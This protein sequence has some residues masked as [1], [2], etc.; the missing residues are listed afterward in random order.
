MGLESA[1]IGDT[2]AVVDP[3][4]GREIYG[5]V[6][7]VTADA[8]GRYIYVKGH[9]IKVGVPSAGGYAPVP[10]PAPAEIYT[11][12]EPP[13]PTGTAVITRVTPPEP[14]YVGVP[15]D[16]RLITLTPMEEGKPKGEAGVYLKTPEKVTYIG[17]M[18]PV[19]K[20]EK[21]I[22]AEISPTGLTVTREK[23]VAGPA[24]PI[25]ET[26][27][28][29]YARVLRSIAGETEET[30]KRL[31]KREE[32]LGKQLGLSQAML[33]STGKEISVGEF[34]QQIAGIQ[35]AKK[36]VKGES[37]ESLLTKHVSEF[38]PHVEEESK[39]GII[40]RTGLMGVG[41]LETISFG[42]ITPVRAGQE[43]GGIVWGQPTGY[44]ERAETYKMLGGIFTV[45]GIAAPGII[46]P[47]FPKTPTITRTATIE[48][49]VGKEG[50]KISKGV[51][52]QEFQVLEP[53]TTTQTVKRFFGFGGKG[54][55]ETYQ[56]LVT[57]MH[58]ADKKLSTG[59][60]KVVL[61]GKGKPTESIFSYGAKSQLLKMERGLGTFYGESK[62]WG[63]RPTEKGIDLFT[64]GKIKSL[65]RERG[66][67]E[68]PEAK[69]ILYGRKARGIS[70]TTE[71]FG[72]GGE[73]AIGKMTLL[74]EQ[75]IFPAYKGRG[76]KTPFVDYRY[77]VHPLIRDLSIGLKKPITKVTRRMRT[78][79][80]DVGYGIARG[81]IRGRYAKKPARPIGFGLLAPRAVSQFPRAGARFPMPK[82][83]AWARL[84]LGY[85]KAP[86]IYKDVFE[87]PKKIPRGVQ[88][89]ADVMFPKAR[90][91]VGL[92]LGTLVPTRQAKK[93]KVGLKAFDKA[94]AG[95]GLKA[96][97]KG[98]TGFG[99]LYKTTAKITA[100][101]RRRERAKTR[102]RFLTSQDFGF[103][104]G[105]G[106]GGL[107][108]LT[109]TTPPP[110]FIIPWFPKGKVRKR[111]AELFGLP[112]VTTK[113]Q[114]SLI[115]LGLDIFGKK[116]KRL[117]GLE[118]RPLLR[119]KRGRKRGWGFI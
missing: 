77:T 29:E 68:A 36:F 107:K 105:P 30:V 118:I 55:K 87:M 8:G 84:G 53:P 38:I 74:R 46:S 109:P 89:Q 7:G 49:I 28:P 92:G 16:S 20:G 31:E 10:Q 50:Q 104:F 43:F 26:K 23:I 111:K 110:P 99:K 93:G 69:T 41:A 85:G 71:G 15:T 60:G 9:K 76:G 17:E 86:K 56:A 80:L 61:F 115:A 21:L 35:R 2:V 106:L 3:K 114:P 88:R 95:F 14:E 34:S 6:T 96:A 22:G 64:A 51:G 5:K 67:L 102:F 91:R 18:E 62:F 44:S 12:A 73:K 94:I 113:Y 47:Y 82:T 97:A 100:R 101:Q 112:K 98:R 4:T 42:G 119:K 59:L 58:R 11:R 117:T 39:K 25:V 116:P 81:M 79:S 78:P 70:Y 57:T 75:R 65:T 1:R 52:Y 108:P 33:T 27:A 37:L 103:A 24:I 83:D 19:E 13:E 32:E 66:I 72:I 40:A 45:A 63:V 90:E 54:K 48:R